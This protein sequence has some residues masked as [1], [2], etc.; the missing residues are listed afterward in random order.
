MGV[1]LTA[2]A[3]RRMGVPKALLDLD[4]EPLIR[5]HVRRF[6][7][8]GLRVVV[9]VGAVIEPI[10]A[11]LPPDVTVVVNPDW[12]STGPAESLA[13][14]LAL[15]PDATAL[16]TPVDVPPA[17]PSTLRALLAGVGDA[18]PTWSGVDGHPVRL[19][20]PHPPGRLDHR[21]V[22]ARRVAVDDPDVVLNLNTPE[23][24]AAW[25]SRRRR[26]TT[27]PG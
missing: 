18:V 22:G 1:V 4:G 2:G 8:A 13:L 27:P 15:A 24:W 21:L 12:E 14:A 26:R 25:L 20:P 16:V 11:I 6:R 19:D 17:R 3:S 9:V 7:D 23:A 5:V 10:R